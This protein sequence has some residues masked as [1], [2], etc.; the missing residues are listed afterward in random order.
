MPSH[1]RRH[2][3]YVMPGIRMMPS[4]SKRGVSQFDKRGTPVEHQA[5]ATPTYPGFPANPSSTNCNPY[6]APA[7]IKGELAPAFWFVNTADTGQ[8]S[9][10]SPTAQP[11]ARGTRWAYIPP[12]TST[13]ASTTSTH[14][15]A[16]FTREYCSSPKTGDPLTSRIS[17][18]SRRAQSH[19][20]SSLTAPLGRQTRPQPRRSP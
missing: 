17:A 20:M 12:T 8:P 4:M 7:C 9:T 11:L 18:P 19:R 2:V 5:R 14:T 6:V 3:D 13:T 16:N 1:I 10:A 15:G